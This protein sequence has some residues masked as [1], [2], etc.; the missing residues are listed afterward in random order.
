MY[1]RFS[2]V[3]HLW[4]ATFTPCVKFARHPSDEA[5]VLYSDLLEGVDSGFGDVENLPVTRHVG[6]KGGGIQ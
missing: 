2:T 5:A 3:T 1:A 4:L 6:R